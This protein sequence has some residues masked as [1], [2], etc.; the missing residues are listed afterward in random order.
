MAEQ[1]SHHLAKDAEVSS[2]RERL[3]TLED[4]MASFPGE[5]KSSTG[6]EYD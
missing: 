4:Q 5:S 3:S 1:S 2:E 6:A